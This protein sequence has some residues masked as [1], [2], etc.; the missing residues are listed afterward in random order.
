MLSGRSRAAIRWRPT[1]R[2]DG[3]PRRTGPRPEKTAVRRSATGGAAH[4]IIDRRCRLLGLLKPELPQQDAL[5][6]VKYIA[7]S[8]PWRSCGQNST[9][10]PSIHDV[11]RTTPTTVEFLKAVE[12]TGGKRVGLPDAERIL[13]IAR[14]LGY[15]KI[16]A[17]RP[18]AGRGLMTALCKRS[19]ATKLGGRF[20]DGR[21][22]SPT[23]G[24]PRS[25]CW[26]MAIGTGKTRLLLRSGVLSQVS[27]GAGA[28]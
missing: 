4:Q 21:R 8:I 18:T 17:R 10:R 22:S 24:L 15:R 6:P 25:A 5:P 14:S 11:R 3:H 20:F 13:E 19:S 9:A 12:R 16:E 23:S 26:S 27:R 7:G 2:R 28:H 1:G